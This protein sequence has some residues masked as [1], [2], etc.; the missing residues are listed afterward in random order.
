MKN[1][2][3]CTVSRGQFVSL[4]YG[5]EGTQFDGSPFGL[6]APVGTVKFPEPPTK[7][8][9]VAG[10][11]LVDILQRKGDLVLVGLPRETF[12]GGACRHDDY[13]ST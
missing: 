9:S 12:Q 4:E 5:V 6:F 11:V 10:W 13:R 1:W 7:G 8:K 2:L 3:A